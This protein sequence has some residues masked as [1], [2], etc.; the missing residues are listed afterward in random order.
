MYPTHMTIVSAVG[1]GF[2][3]AEKAIHRVSRNRGHFA[4]P[5]CVTAT[6]S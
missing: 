4:K 6:T 1:T 3:I 2:L 5:K